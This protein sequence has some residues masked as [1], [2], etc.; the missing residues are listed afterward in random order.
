[1]PST[2]VLG[3]VGVSNEKYCA[4]PGASEFWSARIHGCEGVLAAET[5]AL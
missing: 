1:M 2:S 3:T 4:A 5:S